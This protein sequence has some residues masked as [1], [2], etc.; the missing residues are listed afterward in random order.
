MMTINDVSPELIL[1][2]AHQL[3]RN[4]DSFRAAPLY[5]FVREMCNVTG[6]NA[7]E[8]CDSLGWDAETLTSND[9]PDEAESQS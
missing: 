5:Y 4:R 1:R 2:C 3:L 7:K 8:I 6:T 9:L